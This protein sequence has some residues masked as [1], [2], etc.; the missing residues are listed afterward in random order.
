MTTIGIIS[1]IPLETN[2]FQKAYEIE[3]KISNF[4]SLS[5]ETG[6]C[7]FSPAFSFANNSWCLKIYPN[8]Q[9]SKMSVGCI[10]LYLYLRKSSFNLPISIEFTLGLKKLYGGKMSEHHYEY[11]FKSGNGYGVYGCFCRSELFEEKSDLLPAD[12]LTVFCNL[13]YP[14]PVEISSK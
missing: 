5:E 4:S 1:E 14:E 6:N 9:P 7:Y 11:T 2:V 12:V 8:G 3:W 10:G 13:K